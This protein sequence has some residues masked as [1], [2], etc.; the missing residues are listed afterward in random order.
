[1]RRQ[2]TTPGNGPN[3]GGGVSKENVAITRHQAV[4]DSKSMD[5]TEKVFYSTALAFVKITLRP[6]HVS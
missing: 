3:K 4:W 2:Q 1:M 5:G 6:L